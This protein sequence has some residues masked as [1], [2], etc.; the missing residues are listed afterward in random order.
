MHDPGGVSFI[1][2]ASTVGDLPQ[3]Y[4]LVSGIAAIAFTIW[5]GVLGARF[6]RRLV[7]RPPFD[8]FIN[9]D[10]GLDFARRKDQRKD[11]DDR[12]PWWTK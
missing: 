8:D 6:G 4:R 9:P 11:Q 5:G 7:N 3:A 1:P 12:A 10:E 2:D